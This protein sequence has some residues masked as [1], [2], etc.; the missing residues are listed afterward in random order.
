LTPQTGDDT[1]DKEQVKRDRRLETTD[2]REEKLLTSK[3]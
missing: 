2:Y 1:E 3:Y